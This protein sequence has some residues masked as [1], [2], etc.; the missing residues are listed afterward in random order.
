MTATV[1]KID[2]PKISR[3]QDTFIRIYFKTEDYRWC[4]TDVVPTYRNFARWKLIID[5]GVGTVVEG[6]VF[7]SKYKVDADSNVKIVKKQ[8]DPQVKLF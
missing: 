2:P 8:E 1:T 3:Y 7:K 5:S 6:L 4:Q